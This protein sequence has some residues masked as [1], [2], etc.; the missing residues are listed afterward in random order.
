MQLARDMLPIQVAFHLFIVCRI[1]LS[2][3]TLCNKSLPCISQTIALTDFLPLFPDPR[4]E[5]F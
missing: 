5:T 3:L 2:S 4:S 1:F